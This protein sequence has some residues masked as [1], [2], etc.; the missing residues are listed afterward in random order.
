MVI[1]KISSESQEQPSSPKGNVSP[2]RIQPYRIFT[3]ISRSASTHHSSSYLCSILCPWFR[4]VEYSN[5][6][7]WSLS[8]VHLACFQG[9]AKLWQESVMYS[10]PWIISPLHGYT[11]SFSY[12]SFNRH[13]SELYLWLLWMMTLEHSIAIFVFSFLLYI[14][15]CWDCWVVW[16]L[17]V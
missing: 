15:R 13:M 4:W 5:M 6:W 16:F 14:S 10:L 2:R 3:P 11:S 17:Y 1:I 8:T 9:S 7:F 12:L